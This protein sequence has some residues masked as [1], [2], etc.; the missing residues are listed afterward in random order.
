[1]GKGAKSGQLD[2]FESNFDAEMQKSDPNLA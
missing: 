1:M 2:I